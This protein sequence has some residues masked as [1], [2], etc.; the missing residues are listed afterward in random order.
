MIPPAET[1]STIPKGLRDPLILCFNEVA[2]NFAE[3]R[4]EPAELNAGKFCEVVYTILEGA[5]SGTFASKASKPAKMVDACRALEGKPANAARP[6]DR[7]LRILIPRILPALYEIRNNRGV[8]HVGGDVDPNFQDAV[9]VY[10][11]TSWIMAEL[12]RIFHQVSLEEAQRTVDGLVERKHPVIWHQGGIRRVLDPSL[13]KS[14]QALFLLYSAGGWIDDGELAGWVEYQNLTEFRNKVLRPFHKKR[15]IE[16]DG[17][18][19]R[20]HLTPR[21]SEDVEQRL[22]PKYSI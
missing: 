7:S 15:L 18:L 6:G 10:Q 20:V 3:H 22:L 2:R 4:W 13:L 8:G 12:V 17:N 19:H 9:A 14:D 16:Y 11:M 21:G 1:L 5:V